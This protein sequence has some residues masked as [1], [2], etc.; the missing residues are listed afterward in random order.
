MLGIEYENTTETSIN[1]R[2]EIDLLASRG[3]GTEGG[4]DEH[5]AG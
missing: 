4:G 5:S 1:L 3:Q 2:D